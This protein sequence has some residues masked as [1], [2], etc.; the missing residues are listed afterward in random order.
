MFLQFKQKFKNKNFVKIPQV[1]P[2]S[3]ISTFLYFIAQIQDGHQ[4]WQEND[5]GGKSLLGSAD[6]LWVK[7][8]MKITVARSVSEIVRILCCTQKFKMTTRSGGITIFCI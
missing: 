1:R 7:N 6:T 3:E 8:F 2:I 5:V 4:K